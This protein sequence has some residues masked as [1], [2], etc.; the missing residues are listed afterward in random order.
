MGTHERLNRWICVP[1]FSVDLIA[2]NV[3]VLVRKKF[4]HLAD[5]GVEKFVG[6]LLS[7]IHGW[8]EDAPLAFNLIRA[9]AAGQLW[10]T[11]KPCRAVSGHIELGHHANATIVGVG[12]QLAYFILFV[13][14]VVRS[15]LG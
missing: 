12:Y 14:K 8:V 15:H 9:R 6:P 1:L 2:A 5:E 10:I 7:R 3:K 4:R 11:N 13:V